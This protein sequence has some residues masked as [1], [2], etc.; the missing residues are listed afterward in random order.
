MC[1][2]DAQSVAGEISEGDS[3]RVGRD[4]PGSAGS[5]PRVSA[6]P[7]EEA[8]RRV[9]VEE[10]EGEENVDDVHEEERGRGERWTGDT[11]VAVPFS[12]LQVLE[13]DQ[14]LYAGEG[15]EGS[16]PRKNCPAE[17]MRLETRDQ[18]V[19]NVN[20]YSGESRHTQTIQKSVL[21]QRL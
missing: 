21:Y 2:G 20:V 18:L 17:L 16:I 15:Q 14:I 1:G 8:R 12:F 3:G 9:L 13:G 6:S 5:L 11:A 4:Q 19:S 7:E 10:P